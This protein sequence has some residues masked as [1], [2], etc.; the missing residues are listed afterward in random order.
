MDK[1]PRNAPMARTLIKKQAGQSI[2]SQTS[3]APAKI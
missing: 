3:E 1:L 2:G